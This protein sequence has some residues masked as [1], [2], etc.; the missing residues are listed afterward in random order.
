MQYRKM[1]SDLAEAEAALKRLDAKFREKRGLD[2]DVKADVGALR[3]FFSGEKKKTAARGKKLEHMKLQSF[4]SSGKAPPP[5]PSKKFGVYDDSSSLKAVDPE[6]SPVAVS[7][8][9]VAAPVDSASVEP[10]HEAEDVSV[11]PASA[12]SVWEELV[13]ESTGRTYWFNN[14]TEESTWDDPHAKAVDVDDGG[15]G[16]EKVW[17]KFL[18]DDTGQAFYFN[19]STGETTWDTP[20]DYVSDGEETWT[21]LVDDDTGDTYYVSSKGETQWEKPDSL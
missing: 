15:A 21:E 17:T 20:E 8:D 14:E 6:P 9:D 10:S 7:D 16:E 3:A 13:D 12:D 18:D 2:S 1:K 11:G 19:E 4:R 5:T